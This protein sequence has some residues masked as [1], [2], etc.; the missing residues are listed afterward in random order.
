[1]AGLWQIVVP[2]AGTNMIENPTGES[3]QWQF[4][5]YGN[6][7]GTLA[8]SRTTARWGTRSIAYTPSSGTTDGIYRAGLSLTNGTI[9]TY[10]LYVKGAVGVPYRIY[11]ADNSGNLLGTPTTFTGD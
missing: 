1:M 6:G 9:Y 8:I 10:S 5:G 2:E 11:F 4:T 3:P 7:P